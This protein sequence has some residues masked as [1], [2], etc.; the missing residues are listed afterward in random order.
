MTLCRIK[1]RVEYLAVNKTDR[2][3]VTPAFIV[4]ARPTDSGD[5]PRVGF[6][7]SKK[8]GNAVARSRARRRLKEACR[9]VFNTYAQPGW[10]YVLIG[11][12]AALSHDFKKLQ[13]DLRWALA[14]LQAGADIQRDGKAKRGKAG[15][16]HG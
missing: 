15:K 11:R 1:K 4:Q 12:T 14:K 3:W 10:D 13:A 9:A 16:K 5:A 8:V 2:K 6:T 7:V